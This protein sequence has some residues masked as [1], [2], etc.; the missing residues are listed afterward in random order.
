MSDPR[1]HAALA[2]HL[3][4]LT[5][6]LPTA[7]P[8]SKFTPP[9]ASPYQEAGIIPARPATRNLDYGVI[10]QGLYQVNICYPS[11]TG[12]DAAEARA[13][14]LRDHF[15]AGTELP[16]DGLTVRVTRAPWWTE[17]PMRPG[18]YVLAVTIDYEALL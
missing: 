5:P 2:A 3:V 10:D 4:A 14:A 6:A 12:T 16:R 8:N 15:A 9:T 18:F 11:G 1:I 7:W 17:V 13:Q